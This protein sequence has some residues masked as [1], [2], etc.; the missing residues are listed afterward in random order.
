MECD[1]EP[2]SSREWQI[3]QAIRPLIFKLVDGTATRSERLDLN[4]LILDRSRLMRRT[5]RR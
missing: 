4:H 5:A 1:D 3:D 2:V